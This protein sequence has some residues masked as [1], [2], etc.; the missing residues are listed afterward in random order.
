MIYFQTK[1]PNLGKFWRALEWKNVGILYTHY[2]TV[3]QQFGIF[4]IL[5]PFLY[6]FKRG[7]PGW[8]AN[9]GPLNF[10]YFLIFTTL[11]L[12]HSGSPTRFCILCQEKSGNPGLPKRA[13]NLIFKT[14]G[15]AMAVKPLLHTSS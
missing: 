5:T 6:F 4:C 7:C 2:I 9:P 1:K 12:S 13:N 10:I 3:L 15:V 11:P 8:G 14:T